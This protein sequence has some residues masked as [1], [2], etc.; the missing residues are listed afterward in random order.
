[1]GAAGIG[2]GV[3]FRTVKSSVSSIRQ[4]SLDSKEIQT[5]N[6][7][8]PYIQHH[9]DLNYIVHELLHYDPYVDLDPLL[10]LCNKIMRAYSKFEKLDKQLTPH[11]KL[12]QIPKTIH[13]LAQDI[14]EEAENMQTSL[15]AE[16]PDESDAIVNHVQAIQKIMDDVL[17]NVMMDV[18]VAM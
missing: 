6:A 17:F 16:K 1:M 2:L 10:R 7:S 12:L 3:L 5:F 15:I 4:S 14:K 18:D 11:D 9:D 8:Y 13:D